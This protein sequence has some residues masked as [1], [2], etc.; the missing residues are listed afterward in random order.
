V[1]IS[2]VA[3]RSACRYRQQLHID[4]TRATFLACS[5]T[6]LPFAEASF[7]KIVCS[8]VLEHI[9]N[10]DDAID[11]ICRV[12]MPNTRLLV[13]VPNTYLTLSW[14]LALIN[15]Y[16]DRRVGHIRHYAATDIANRF[17][18][19]G[20]RTTEVV[21]HGHLIKVLQLILA[22]FLPN[23]RNNTSQLWWALEQWDLSLKNDPCAVNV[24]I[25][26]ERLM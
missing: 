18:R 12:S 19:R 17:E 25:T 10:D 11:E 3:C 8:A 5:A 23:L 20:F 21:Y 15:F 24:S 16:N 2:T 4:H 7:N 14:P 22:A 1:D 6:S 13:V 26:L 9:E